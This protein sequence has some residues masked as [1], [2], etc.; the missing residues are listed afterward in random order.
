MKI[1]E[2]LRLW[3]QGYTQREIA[4]SLNCSKTTVAGL[5]KRLGVLGLKYKTAK[6]MSDDAIN[7][8]VYPCCHSGRTIKKEPDW[9]TLQKRLDEDRRLNLQFLF[10][11]YRDKEKDGVSRSQFYVRYAAWKAATG[12]DVVMVQERE[13][14]KELFVDWMGDTLECVLDSETGKMVKAHF[15]EAT[16]GDSGYPVVIAFPNEKSE[17]WV[18]AH[19]ETFNRLGGLPLIVKPD[20][21]K[22][23]VSK[24]NYYDPEINKAYYDMALYYNIAIIP[25]RVREPRDKSQV[26]GSI[27]WLETWLL[28][29]LKTKQFTSF[30]ELNAVIKNRVADLAKR[31]FQKRA[32][33]RESV[34]LALDRPAL[35]P[36][37]SEPFVNPSYV[38]RRVPNNY[39]VEYLG[40]YYSV[41]HQYY[42]QQV[43][44]KAT[45]SAI[46][47][48][49]DRLNRIAFHERRYTGSRYVTER[50]HMPLNHQ[51]QHDANRFDGQRYRSW[52]SSI[53]ANTFFVI[54]TLL[55]ERE[56]EQTA[57]RSCMGILQFSRKDGNVRLEAACSK[58]RKLG[59]VSFAVIKN[60]LKNHQEDTPSLFE[61]TQV[62]TPEHENLRGQKAFA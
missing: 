61:F 24:A 50:S 47:V 36:L 31:P 58:A 8:Q 10:E 48:Y 29:W 17:S 25:A 33:S 39:H 6:D 28:S 37:P 12:K 22:T 60:I 16:L 4:L 13:P 59:N 11:E 5:Q 62:V 23:A 51:A 46:E 7:K 42:K 1:I 9:E 43:T 41:P 19:V 53:G 26:E 52:A 49:A 44:I 55:K 38:E 57:Y 14:G 45:H 15:F 30:T 21:C 34:F 2:V 3:E 56:V 18:A 27:G 40:F 32:G 54:D 20:N 35:R